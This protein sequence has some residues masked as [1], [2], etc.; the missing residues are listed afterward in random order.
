MYLFDSNEYKISVTLCLYFIDNHKINSLHQFS[1]LSPKNFNI[2]AVVIIYL[3]EH[4]SLL[5]KDR[6]LIRLIKHHFSFILLFHLRTVNFIYRNILVF[7]C[8]Q[9]ITRNMCIFLLNW[10]QNINRHNIYNMTS[11]FLTVFFYTL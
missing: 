2:L 7:Y 3:S 6:I 1:N 9:C 11:F 5:F 10:S 8:I 4:K